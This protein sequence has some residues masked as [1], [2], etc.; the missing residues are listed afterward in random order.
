[1]TGEQ[2]PL[3]LPAR[4]GS[5]RADFIVSAANALALAQID[6]WRDWP[7]GRLALIGPQG[8]GKSHLI[9]VWAAEAGAEVLAAADLSGVAPAAAHVAVEDVPRIAGQAAAERALLHLHN[10]VLS[11]GGRLLVTGIGP[12]GRWG[13]ALPDLAS[14]LDAAPVARLERP[15]DALLAALLVK[16][17]ADRGIVPPANLI[18][19]LVARMERSFTEAGRIVA[20]LDARSLATGRP[21]GRALA[22]EVLERP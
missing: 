19:W 7:G 14:R 21:V 18:P 20:A 15:D 2:L 22:R 10:E 6:G 5:G 3:D 13:I 4:A 1:M 12:P 9:R 8:A 16:L 11:R 17:F